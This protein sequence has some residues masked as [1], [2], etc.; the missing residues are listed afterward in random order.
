M[1]KISPGLIRMVQKYFIWR[2]IFFSI[3]RR[4][5]HFT[6]FLW[7]KIPLNFL[8]R[9]I[10]FSCK[11]WLSFSLWSHMPRINPLL[12]PINRSVLK[13]EMFSPVDW[14]SYHWDVWAK[15]CC[16][17]RWTFKPELIWRSSS[18][19]LAWNVP[20]FAMCFGVYKWLIMIHI[21]KS[22]RAAVKEQEERFVFSRQL[23]AK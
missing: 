23:R 2:T 9:K 17:L 11:P 16:A 20:L 21:K 1:P 22:N 4:K 18:T 5:S 6:S 3:R 19:A 14:L 12:L 10:C 8:L 7:R 13:Q 15:Q